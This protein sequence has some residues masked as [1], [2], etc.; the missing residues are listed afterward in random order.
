MHTPLLRI[1][2]YY[3]TRNLDNQEPCYK[4]TLSN[5][6][7]I[8]DNV[9]LW[10]QHYGLQGPPDQGSKEVEST[11]IYSPRNRRRVEGDRMLNSLSTR[12]VA[13]S[14]KEKYG[15]SLDSTVRTR[16]VERVL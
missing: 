8:T 4:V 6:M 1:N 15:F 14:D 2:F 11:G 16:T 10:N 5:L 13:R 12:K 9:S 7:L 3:R